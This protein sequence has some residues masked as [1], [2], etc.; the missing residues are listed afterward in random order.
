MEL[1][2][3]AC[4]TFATDFR[5]CLKRLEHECR[6]GFRKSFKHTEQNSINIT[7][8]TAKCIDSDSYKAYK[9]EVH[10]MTRLNS[11][12]CEFKYMLYA[13]YWRHSSVCCL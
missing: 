2:S 11:F 5:D 1:N 8:M 9:Y 10:A 3:T 7:I 12:F 13:E 6:L 4:N